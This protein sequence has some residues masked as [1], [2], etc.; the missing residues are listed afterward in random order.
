VF[1]TLFT[2]E[3][4]QFEDLCETKQVTQG[5]M[6]LDF[7]H[8]T[9]MALAK[10]LHHV[11]RTGLFVPVLPGNDGGILYR[12]KD[13]KWYAVAGTK[14][15][16]WVEAEMAKLALDK[17]GTHIT[18]AGFIDWSY[19]DNLAE[20]ARKAIDYFGEFTRFVG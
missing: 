16:L 10:G 2:G 5:I 19:F 13:E 15:H 4:I 20:E 8:D 12:I 1:K 7:D 3:P 14:G 18:T 6:Y 11:G 17:S 9:P